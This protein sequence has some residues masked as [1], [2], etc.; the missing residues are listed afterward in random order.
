MKVFEL[1][2]IETLQG[3]IDIEAETIEDAIKIAYANYGDGLIELS[4]EDLNEI[5][6]ESVRG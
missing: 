1:T 6:I 2:V 4:S 5:N 3:F